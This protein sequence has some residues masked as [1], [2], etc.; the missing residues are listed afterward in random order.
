ML[1]LTAETVLTGPDGDR[2]PGGAVLVDGTTIVATGPRA[3][4]DRHPGAAGAEHRD[5]PGATI[6]PGLINGHAHL[7]WDASFAMLQHYFDA[8][9]TELLLGV[10]GR[11]Q[12]ALRAGVTTLRDLGDRRGLV[13]RVRDAINR[14]ELTGPRLLG[15]AAPLTPPKGHCWFFGGEVDGIDAIRAQVRHNADLGADVIK[16]MASGGETTPDSPPT[17]AQ[18]FSAEELCVVVAEATA[19][20][21][22]V[23]AHAHGAQS[24]ADAVAAGVSTIE[25]CSWLGAENSG[26]D[27]REDV[28]REIGARGIAVCHAYP[29]DWRGF[30]EFVGEQRFQA[31]LDRVRWMDQ[32]GVTF[33]PGTDGGLPTSVFDNY[34]G[35]LSYYV[36]AVGWTPG[37]VVEMA[38]TGAAAAL[39]LDHVGRVAEGFDADLLVVDGDPSADIHALHRQRLV[40]ARGEPVTP[41]TN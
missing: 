13:L 18:Q 19:A 1:L 20:G 26:P 38:T 5:F 41:E 4:I 24:I 14:G 21:L 8:D 15:S 16:V 12:Q 30:A 28:A 11:S 39:G 7:V 27:L 34:A 17:W 3:E 37:R 2:I 31:A 9:D 29:P 10:V 36:E 25:H 40:V 23:A 35:A 33:L 6:L 32:H 22:P